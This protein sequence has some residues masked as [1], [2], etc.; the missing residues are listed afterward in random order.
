MATRRYLNFDLL[1][2]QEG[3]G[4]YQARVTDSPLGETPSVHFEL[5]F[6]ATTLENLLL[7]LDPGRSGTR[8]VGGNG[9]CSRR[10]WT[11]AA[12]STRRS[13]PATWRSRGAQPGPGAQPRTPVACGS[14][15][16]STTRRPSPGCRGSCCTTPA[17]TTSSR[18]R[19]GPRWCASSTCRRC[20]SRWRSTAPCGCWRSSP[21]RPTS[22][23]STSRPSGPGSAT[24]SAPDLDRPG[25]P[26]PAAEPD[27]LGARHLA[28]PLGDPRRALRR[29]RRLRPGVARGGHLLPGPDRAPQRGHL[30]DAG[31]LPPRPRPAADGGPQRLPVGAHRHHRPVRRD[32]PGPRAAGRLRGRRDAVPHQRPAPP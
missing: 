18:S 19:S 20:P 21:R 28:A 4:R 12:R 16:G 25:R 3:E 5:P 22:T 9:P 10:R 17:P 1:L 11:S 8:R 23:S 15:S 2:E 6:D 14:G 30:V 13:S 27:A 24:P 31:P 7:K 32:G 26:R 29:P